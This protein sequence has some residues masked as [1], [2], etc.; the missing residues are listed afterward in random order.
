MWHSLH[1]IPISLQDTCCSQYPH[2]KMSQNLGP[3]LTCT[4]PAIST[5]I[6]VMSLAGL[7][8]LREVWDLGTSRSLPAVHRPSMRM[9][10]TWSEI[11]A[12]KGVPGRMVSDAVGLCATAHRLHSIQ[13]NKKKHGIVSWWDM[14][15]GHDVTHSHGDEIESVIG[16]AYSGGSCTGWSSI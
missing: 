9:C 8:E 10:C 6:K 4:S 11:D 16:L 7:S 5:T 13:N 3:G 1:A 12:E 14:F 2:G 15:I